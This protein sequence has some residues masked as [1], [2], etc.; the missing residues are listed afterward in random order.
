[1]KIIYIDSP[2]YGV[3]EVMVDDEDYEYLSQFKWHVYKP[4]KTFYARKQTPGGW[5]KGQ[6]DYMHRMILN[7]NDSKI[8]VDHKDHNGLNNQKSNIRACTHQQNCRNHPSEITST[9]KFIGVS[10]S[11]ERKKWCAQIGH[12]RKT[13]PLG[14]Y[15]SEEEAARVRDKKAKELFGEFANLNFPS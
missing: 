6:K 2:K 13:I 4:W 7:L 15:S 12:N 8:S 3:K 11:I 9:S 14:R 1:M 10:Y 5:R